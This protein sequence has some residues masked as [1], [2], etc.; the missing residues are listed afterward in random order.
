MEFKRRHNT[1][2]Q[3]SIASSNRN[4]RLKNGCLLAK[5]RHSI[6]PLFPRRS[7]ALRLER[8]PMWNM[9]RRLE[10]SDD[11]LRPYSSEYNHA[12]MLYEYWLP[13]TGPSTTV[14]GNCLHIPLRDANLHLRN[15]LS[16]RLY[17]NPSLVHSRSNRYDYTDLAFDSIEF[18]LVIS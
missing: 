4:G 17:P 14:E 1:V 13:S 15:R 3:L 12:D 16:R 7:H 9:L 6:K 5:G 18:S 11:H 8:H 10:Y 2:T